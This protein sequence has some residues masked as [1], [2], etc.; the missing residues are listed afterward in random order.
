MPN[1]RLST[2]GG[3]VGSHEQELAKTAPQKSG[4]E[5]RLRSVSDTPGGTKDTEKDALICLS[6]ET[7]RRRGQARLREGGDRVRRQS[8]SVGPKMLKNAHGCISAKDVRGPGGPGRQ[9]ILSPHMQGSKASTN[10]QKT[11]SESGGSRAVSSRGGGTREEEE[12]QDLH[13]KVIPTL[14]SSS[15]CVRRGGHLV[16]AARISG[17]NHTSSG[18]T[19]VGKGLTEGR[20]ERRLV[21]EGK[22]RQGGIVISNPK[23]QPSSMAA[24][25]RC[26]AVLRLPL[27]GGSRR[28]TAG[29]PHHQDSGPAT[30]LVPCWT[31][32]PKQGVE[33]PGSPCCHPRTERTG[34][35]EMLSLKPSPLSGRIWDCSA[36]L[37]SSF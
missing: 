23:E 12:N 28:P 9:S 27:I 14:R 33:I 36:F 16:K 26:R 6:A 5:R 20:M 15:R 3:R 25:R 21:T 18:G 13:K 31:Y 22:Q 2:E 35:P 24:R 34:A 7:T 19:P 32:G 37:L 4:Q 30:V 8:H 17:E 10:P 29:P 11:L 1:C